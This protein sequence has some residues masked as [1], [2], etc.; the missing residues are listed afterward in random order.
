MH[1]IGGWRL[2]VLLLPERSTF[3]AG[4]PIFLTFKVHN[5]S[6]EYL[7]IY[8][9]GDTRNRLNR[10]EAYRVRVKPVGGNDLPV[11]EAGPTLGGLAYPRRMMPDDG[12]N[13]ELFLPN[14]VHITRPGRYEIRCTR[15]LHV[16]KNNPKKYRPKKG[17]RG[18]TVTAR[19]LVTVTAANAQ[20]MDKLFKELSEIMLGNNYASINKAARALAAIRDPRIVPYFVRAIKR[21]RYQSN[22]IAA[23]VF[24]RFVTP[25]A[26]AGLKLCKDHRTLSVRRICAKSLATSQH[27]KAWALLLSL[28]DDEDQEVRLTV[29]AALGSKGCG[30]PIL[31]LIKKLSADDVDKVKKEAKRYLDACKKRRRP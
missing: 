11:R 1:T 22:L 20:R 21:N 9:G 29:L 3:M 31:K 15:V 14:W 7:Q 6:K 30:K 2:E 18:V 25:A 17:E 4:E 16:D 24:G 28:R 5:H 26:L 12:F 23:R 19:V 27:P 10:P 8:D 13:R